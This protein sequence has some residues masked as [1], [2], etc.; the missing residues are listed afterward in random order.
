MCAL[1]GQNALSQERAPRCNHRPT[2]GG[3]VMA[4]PWNMRSDTVDILHTEVSLDF[5]AMPSS[6]IVGD[7]RLTCVILEATAWIHLD[8]Q[9]L[10]IGRAHV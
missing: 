1:A 7:A 2:R 10:Q 3:D 4:D 9:G 8:F 5:T 6:D